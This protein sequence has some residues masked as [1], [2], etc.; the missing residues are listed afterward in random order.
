MLQGLTASPEIWDADEAAGP[1][2]RESFRKG[3]YIHL[4]D[5]P[6]DAERAARNLLSVGRA[7]AAIDLLAANT[8]NAWL[9]GDGDV[10][11]VVD[12][13]NAGI[14]EANANRSHAERVAH[15]IA[16]LIKAL[17]DSKRLDLGELM[18]LEWIYFGV[19]EHQRQHDLVIYRNLISNPNLLL[20]LV[21]LMY[22][23]EGESREERPEPSESERAAAMQAWRILHNWKPFA[24][25]SPDAMPSAEELAATAEQVRKLA[26]ER[27]YLGIV[28]DLVG[29]ALASSPLGR[30]GIWPHESV[31]EV[32][33][34]YSS[35]A[36]AN[37]FV[38]GKQNLRGVTSRS[39]G[40]GG[41]QE[42][43]LAAQYE[44]WQ[45][46][47]AVSHPRTSALLGR[48]AE[49]YRSDANREDVEVRKR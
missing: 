41:E 11:L 33:E 38:I 44:G 2:C 31:R 15:D 25:A 19:L 18:Q 30:D 26:E 8:K 12:A 29:K 3:V 1:L 49:A 14:A 40:D 21:G 7:L 5:R 9:A 24:G 20:Q 46:A 32:L 42:R 47:L 17:A 10:P 28:D 45:R 36:L 34:R 48:L 23:P 39:L 22:I 35:E 43:Q 6:R 13:L 4:F 37:G 27:C 16:R